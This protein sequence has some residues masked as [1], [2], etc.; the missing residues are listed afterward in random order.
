MGIIAE[1]EPVTL[2][3]SLL[4]QHGPDI[5]LQQIE[6]VLTAAN[7]HYVAT[8][9]EVLKPL[10]GLCSGRKRPQDAGFVISGADV[11]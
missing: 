10:R 6:Q 8:H 11:P 3:G 7:E 4:R 2:I 9:P 5:T 1:G